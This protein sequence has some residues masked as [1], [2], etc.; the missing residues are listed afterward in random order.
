MRKM[1]FIVDEHETNAEFLWHVV[2]VSDVII[3]LSVTR[4]SGQITVKE[5]VVERKKKF[6]VS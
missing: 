4:P 2:S 3:V 5:H 1:S 6:C